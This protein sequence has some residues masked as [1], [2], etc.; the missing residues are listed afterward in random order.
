MSLS[1]VGLAATQTRHWESRSLSDSAVLAKPGAVHVVWLLR[2]V[3]LPAQTTHRVALLRRTDAHPVM[4]AHS[5]KAHG[6]L[7]VYHC[8]L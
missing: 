6:L 5:L 1:M 4:L 8:S 7:R 3:A 2:M